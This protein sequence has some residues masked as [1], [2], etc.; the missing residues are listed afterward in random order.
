MPLKDEKQRKE[1][2]RLWHLKHREERLAKDKLRREKPE[3]KERHSENAKRWRSANREK[4]NQAMR[5]YRRSRPH[6]DV[7]RNR[8]YR[9]TLRLKVIEH[10]GGKCVRCN[11]SDWRGL[12]IDHINGGG[13]KSFGEKRSSAVYYHNSLLKEIPGVIYQLLCANCNQIKKYE[14]KEYYI[15]GQQATRKTVKKGLSI[16]QTTA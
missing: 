5:E 8:N 9:E 7:I 12:Q 16:G 6:Y 11:F 4:V 13:R 14:N 2:L 3:N 10:F 1:Y 15:P